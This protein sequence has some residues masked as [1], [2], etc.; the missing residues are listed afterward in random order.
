VYV[1]EVFRTRDALR[2]ETVSDS[3]WLDRARAFA[4]HA[5]EQSER[6]LREFGQRR[7]SLWT[8]DLGL[9]HYLSSC[10]EANN[11]FPTMDVF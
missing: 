11:Q 10:I 1:V 5:I 4:M 2:Q 8:G 6:H 9:A 3:I 7:Y